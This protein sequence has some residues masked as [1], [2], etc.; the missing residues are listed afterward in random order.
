MTFEKTY[1][2]QKNNQLIINLPDRFKS[3]KMV[4]VIIEDIDEI[5]EGKIAMLKK[6]SSDPLFLSDIV[7][8]VS[9]FENS[10]NELL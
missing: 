2:I 1:D 7:E 10:D 6:A 8:T 9:D 3:K 4:R 5:R